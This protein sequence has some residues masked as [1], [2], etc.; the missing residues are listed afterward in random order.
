MLLTEYL[1][2]KATEEAGE[3]AA[4][5]V[6][7]N[8]LGL[9]P[10]GSSKTPAQEIGEEVNDVM[11]FI[12]LLREEGIL[13]ENIGDTSDLMDMRR[14][15]AEDAMDRAGE[16]ASEESILYAMMDMGAKKAMALSKAFTKALAF[17][18]DSVDPRTELTSR[19]KIGKTLNDVLSLLR[20]LHESG[21]VIPGIGDGAYLLMRREKA[22]QS[23]IVAQENGIISVKDEVIST[24]Q[25]NISL[26]DGGKPPRYNGGISQSRPYR[27]PMEDSFGIGQDTGSRED[28]DKVFRIVYGSPSAGDASPNDILMI[29]QGGPDDADRI[30]NERPVATA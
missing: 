5:F 4:A 1:L 10:E 30:V 9:S 25:G 3:L 2:V 18:I 26:V 22:I 27:E 17:G 28:I 23:A 11:T 16:N 12:G 8:L 14:N 29:R 15:A 19:Q 7:G 21:V 13:I 24:E 6:D 20:M